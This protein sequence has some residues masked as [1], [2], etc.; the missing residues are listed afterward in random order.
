MSKRLAADEERRP[1][2]TR[3]IY[4][5]AC[6]VNAENVNRYQRNSDGKTGKS[7]RRRSSVS[8]QG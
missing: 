2:A 5:H 8:S 7:R 1:Q 6:N 3:R 4:A